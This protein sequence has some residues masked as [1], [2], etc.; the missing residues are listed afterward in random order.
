MYNVCLR[1]VFMHNLTFLV[2]VVY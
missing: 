2:K 1:Y